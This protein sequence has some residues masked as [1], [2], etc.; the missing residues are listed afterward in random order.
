M[1]G[2]RNKRQEVIL[3][4]RRLW[5]AQFPVNTF[6]ELNSKDLPINDDPMT[7]SKD[8][9]DFSAFELSQLDN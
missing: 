7:H 9:T 1:P 2:N 5:K 3:G 8:S 6:L 4:R